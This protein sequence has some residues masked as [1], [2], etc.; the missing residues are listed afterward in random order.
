MV[1][2]VVVMTPLNSLKKMKRHVMFEKID[3]FNII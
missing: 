2:N 1:T 3:G